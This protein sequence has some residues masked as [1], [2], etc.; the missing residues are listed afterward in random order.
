MESRAPTMSVSNPFS[1][2]SQKSHSPKPRDRAHT[3]KAGKNPNEVVVLAFLMCTFGRAN[4]EQE[5]KNKPQVRGVIGFL[6]QKGGELLNDYWIERVQKYSDLRKESL[7]ESNV[8]TI[9]PI[10]VSLCERSSRTP[11]RLRYPTYPLPVVTLCN[12]S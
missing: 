6:I 1:T 12:Q 5:Y 2:H 9:V 8:S 4:N 3:Q 7:T 11:V 10:H